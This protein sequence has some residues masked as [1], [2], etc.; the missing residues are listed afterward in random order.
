MLAHV[1]VI[2]LNAVLRVVVEPIQI[3]LI[4]ILTLAGRLAVLVAPQMLLALQI[5]VYGVHIVMVA[6]VYVVITVPVIKVAMVIATVVVPTL[7][8]LMLVVVRQIPRLPIVIQIPMDVPHVVQVVGVILI[9]LLI[10]H[11]VLQAQHRGVVN[12]SLF[13]IPID[14][15]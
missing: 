8:V 6:S 15:C 12:V 9:A 3:V 11:I 7:L 1:L 5:I 14:G 2:K 10:H 13:Q 4:G